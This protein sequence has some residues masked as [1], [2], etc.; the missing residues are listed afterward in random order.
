[1]SFTLEVHSIFF[2]F[3]LKQIIQSD[4]HIYSACKKFS[5][6][7]LKSIKKYLHFLSGAFQFVFFQPTIFFYEKL[8]ISIC[9]YHRQSM[10]RFSFIYTQKR[11]KLNGWKNIFQ[12][13][14]FCATWPHAENI[15]LIFCVKQLSHNGQVIMSC[16]GTKI[17]IC[18]CEK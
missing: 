4:F 14:S 6:F 1:M 15:Y 16:A 10:N 7:S 9:M 12:A 17:S 5:F 3:E 11:E 8:F 13:C 18:W 2:L